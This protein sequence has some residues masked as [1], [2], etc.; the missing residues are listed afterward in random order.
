MTGAEQG[1]SEPLIEPPEAG[2]EIRFDDEEVASIERHSQYI[3]KGLKG[4]VF[5]KGVADTVETGL[6]A[7]ALADLARTRMANG[8]L[9][10]AASSAMKAIGVAAW[11]PFAWLRL[12]EAHARYGD[13][14]RA[15]SLLKKASQA[16]RGSGLSRK[17]WDEFTQ[18]IRELVESPSSTRP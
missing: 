16:A 6:I 10:G 4:Y 13:A 2:Q 18:P 5:E 12:A 8:D 7:A 17:E 14:R 3:L 1:R 9:H 11:Y 15:K